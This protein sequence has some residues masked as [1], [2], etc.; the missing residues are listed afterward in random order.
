MNQTQQK[1]LLKRIVEIAA[2]LVSKAHKKYEKPAVSPTAEEMVA[3][4][5]SGT[6]KPNFKKAMAT[7]KVQNNSSKYYSCTSTV[8]YPCFSSMFNF[9]RYHKKAI[10]SKKLP[11]ALQA[12]AKKEQSLSDELILGDSEAALKALDSFA[13]MKI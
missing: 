8:N 9:D 3:L 1:Y 13:K 10:T 4:I 12:I 6:V 11:G 2:D 5:N 7:I